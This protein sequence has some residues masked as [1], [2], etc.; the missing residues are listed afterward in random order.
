MQTAVRNALAK[1]LQPGPAREEPRI[2]ADVVEAVRL[3]LAD[4][5]EA[6]ALLL[7]DEETELIRTLATAAVIQRQVAP[8]Q[9]EALIEQVVADVARSLRGRA[10]PLDAALRDPHVYDVMVNAPDVIWVRRGSE[11]P[12]RLRES[13]PDNAEVDAFVSR[14]ASR[15]HR[16]FTSAEPTLD[17]QMPD[18]TRLN[19]VQY[20]V[21]RDGTALTLRLHAQFPAYE[22][23]VSDYGLVPDGAEDW[24]PRRVRRRPKYP[25]TEASADDFLRWMVV[26]GARFAV[27]G[28]TGAGKT[29]LFN[30]LLGLVP[31]EERLIVIED[32][33]EIRLPQPN[34]IHLETR[35]HVPE[36][37]RVITQYML[38]ENA[39]RMYPTRLL[40]GEVRRGDVLFAWLRAALSGHPGSA[41]TFHATTVADFLGSATQELQLAMPSMTTDTAMRRLVG[42]VQVVI[43]YGPHPEYGRRIV[44]EIAA[45]DVD[46]RRE[47]RITQLY[48]L[49]EQ[50]P[51]H[52]ALV[53]T[54]QK[55]PWLIPEGYLP[56]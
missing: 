45:L 29:T 17:L 37:A 14:Y 25:G 24:S 43:R 10:G 51:G 4:R 52:P 49:E 50:I 56:I 22:E 11:P 28:G 40:L 44:Q 1:E 21:A 48:R 9:R 32:T 42:A 3:D 36:G 12:V 46:E 13:F 55:P 8:A 19:A 54:G 39:L 15:A 30:A 5:R 7:P 26:A 41:F 6:E 35:E 38:V 20:P 47:P 23:L 34:V 53:G 33:R 27:I 18:G 2:R 31:P 16:Q